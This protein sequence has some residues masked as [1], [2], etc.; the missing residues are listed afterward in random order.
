MWL[1]QSWGQGRLSW[2]GRDTGWEEPAHR[3]PP[4]TPTPPGLSQAAQAG[5]H[6]E[7][8]KSA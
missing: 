6:Y 8:G 7:M 3:P 2:C 1:V 5:D 4:P